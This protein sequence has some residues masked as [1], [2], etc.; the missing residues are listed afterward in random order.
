ME[1]FEI[2]VDIENQKTTIKDLNTGKEIAIS[3]DFKLIDCIKLIMK[4][5]LK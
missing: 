1:K 3:L 2:T 4:Q 5:N